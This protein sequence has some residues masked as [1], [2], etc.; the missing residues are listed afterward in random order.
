MGKTS[1]I[2]KPYVAL[3]NMY[4]NF[5]QMVV[6]SVVK[7]VV[8]NHYHII[9]ALKYISFQICKYHESHMICT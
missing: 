8:S 4:V 3:V 2:H 9:L 5:R 7:N 6:K 1:T